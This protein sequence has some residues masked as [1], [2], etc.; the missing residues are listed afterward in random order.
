MK[1]NK[2]TKTPKAI[3][4]LKWKR[5]R[6]C[7]DVGF[8]EEPDAIVYRASGSD[9][10]FYISLL[11]NEKN[12]KKTDV[13]IYSYDVDSGDAFHV[14]RTWTVKGTLERTDLDVTAFQQTLLLQTRER[15]RERA[16]FVNQL[17]SLSTNFAS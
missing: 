16:D 1:T 3:K 14:D 12:P 5:S 4:P 10:D 11:P 15:L 13:S 8:D 7:L 6:E 2:K 9:I 17:L